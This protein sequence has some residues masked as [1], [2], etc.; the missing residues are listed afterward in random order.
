VTAPASP[1]RLAIPLV[2]V[3]TTIPPG[4][5]IAEFRRSNAAARPSR[6]TRRGWRLTRSHASCEDRSYLRREPSRRVKQATSKTT[7]PAR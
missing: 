3:E 1:F 7:V 4:M 2:Y 6:R 5:T